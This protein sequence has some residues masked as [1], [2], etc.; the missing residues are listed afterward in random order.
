MKEETAKKFDLAYR[1]GLIFST[2]S[3]AGTAVGVTVAAAGAPE[4]GVEIFKYSLYA[5]AGFATAGMG[6]G[7][8]YRTSILGEL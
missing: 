1:L 5:S 6:A 4:L 7:M 8:I 2:A 3:F